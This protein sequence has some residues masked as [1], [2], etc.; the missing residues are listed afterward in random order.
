[1]LPRTGAFRFAIALLTLFAFTAQ[2]V[3]TQTHIHAGA[4]AGAVTGAAL[5]A[6]PRAPLPDKAPSG[7]DS[8][9]C[10]ICQ[11]LLHAGAY[12][13]PST[14]AVLTLSVTTFVNIVALEVIALEQA[15]SHAWKSRAPPSA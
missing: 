13:T 15:N 7:D 1:M 14:V 2:T 9:N 6:I 8:A 10:P 4:H 5:A 12:V 3:V 11:G